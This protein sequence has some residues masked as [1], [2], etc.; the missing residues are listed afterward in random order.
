LQPPHVSKFECKFAGTGHS[1]LAGSLPA[2]GNVFPFSRLV[3][4]AQTLLEMLPSPHAK[5]LVTDIMRE[6]TPVSVALCE[7]VL[8]HGE[9]QR[10]VGSLVASVRG[11]LEALPRPHA[12]AIVLDLA[13]TDSPVSVAFRDRMRAIE[14]T[15][16][17]V[18]DLMIVARDLLEALPS[19]HARA[20]ASDL[21]RSSTPVSAAVRER[22]TWTPLFPE[23]PDSAFSDESTDSPRRPVTSAQPEIVTALVNGEGDVSTFLVQQIAQRQWPYKP[24]SPADL[25]GTDTM[26]VASVQL[27]KE[28]Q[29]LLE[30]LSDDEAVKVLVML[31][32]S[33]SV[34]AGAMRSRMPGIDHTRLFLPSDRPSSALN[35]LVLEG[36]TMLDMMPDEMSASMVDIISISDGHVAKQLR[37]KMQAASSPAAAA[38]RELAKESKHLIYGL[39]DEVAKDLL[40]ATMDGENSISAV[41]RQQL[42]ELAAIRPDAEDEA[43]SFWQT[44]VSTASS[45]D[46]GAW[47][48]ASRRWWRKPVDNSFDSVLSQNATIVHQM[49][50]ELS[51]SRASTTKAHSQFLNSMNDTASW[52]SS[53]AK[54]PVKDPVD[55]NRQIELKR[56]VQSVTFFLMLHTSVRKARAD[57]AAR[58][59]KAEDMAKLKKLNTLNEHEDR[60]LL[61]VRK[62]VL[63]STKARIQTEKEWRAA[64]NMERLKPLTDM[65]AAL[66]V[67][68]TFCDQQIAKL[69]ELEQWRKYNKRVMKRNIR[70][71]IEVCERTDLALELILHA[72]P[73]TDEANRE[74]LLEKEGSGPHGQRPGMA[75]NYKTSQSSIGEFARIFFLSMKT[76]RFLL[77]GF[78]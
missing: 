76:S 14:S 72:L 19:P 3:G 31:L 38:L 25:H 66:N 18:G 20:L 77:I 36:E 40:K 46:A 65:V 54:P 27:V 68:V 39:P 50:D 42:F 49:K 16:S 73:E 43:F 64:K 4:E 28:G 55:V 11:L 57:Y 67:S 34:L 9:T 47:T 61:A 62:F 8:E 12:R 15:H 13:R 51:M 35:T 7:R 71:G 53:R 58:L 70:E 32:E 21:A 24:G 41:M 10:E 56:S 2:V 48:G 26:H 22:I 78:F 1:G 29:A 63:A 60:A 6:Q 69:E 59:R 30:N 23:R 44:R 74:K 37:A 75:G 45:F 5:A 17:D 52:F 33:D